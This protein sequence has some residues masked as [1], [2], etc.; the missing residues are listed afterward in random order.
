MRSDF[1]LQRFDKLRLDAV[2]AMIGGSGCLQICIFNYLIVLYIQFNY[3]Y[4]A[5]G[6]PRPA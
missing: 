2:D 4:T 1:S 6:G 5:R 3:S